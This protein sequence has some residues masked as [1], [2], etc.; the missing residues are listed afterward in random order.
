MAVTFVPVILAAKLS[1][2]SAIVGE[3]VIISASV[4]DIEVGP[5]EQLLLTGEFRSGEV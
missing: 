5:K 1:S 3:S 4:A 2:T